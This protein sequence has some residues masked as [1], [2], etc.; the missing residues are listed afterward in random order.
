MILSDKHQEDN[1]V[2]PFNLA[3]LKVGEFV[4]KFILV[5]LVLANPNCTIAPFEEF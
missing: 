3:A 5:A 4:F 2:K 1:T